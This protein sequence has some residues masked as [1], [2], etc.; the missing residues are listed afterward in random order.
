ML[1]SGIPR[2]F[3]DT[4]VRL[5]VTSVEMQDLLNQWEV[6]SARWGS[7]FDPH[8]DVQQALERLT[9][10]MHELAERLETPEGQRFERNERVRAAVLTAL[11]EAGGVE[12]VSRSVG[13]PPEGVYRALLGDQG[14]STTLMQ[15]LV[16]GCK[17]KGR[18][19]LGRRRK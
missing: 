4:V 3:V 11:T 13:V 5:S 19:L 12:P 7:Y 1:D 14:M 8:G 10:D 16:Q 2:P 17:Q 6:E 18:T 9:A 15:R